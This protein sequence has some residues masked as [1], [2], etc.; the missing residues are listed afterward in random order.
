M[1]SLQAEKQAVR[2]A[3][4]VRRA[5]A[6]RAAPDAGDAANAVFRRD[7]RIRASSIVAGYLPIGDEIDPRPLLRRLHAA[8]HAIAL[9]RIVRSHAPLSFRVWEEGDALEDGPFGTLQPGEAAPAI[10]PE[11][12]VLPLLAFDRRGFRLGYGGGYYD[13]TLAEL[14]SRRAVTAIGIA[15]AAQEVPSVPHDRHDRPLDWVVTE[16]EAIETEKE[17]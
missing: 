1:A 9:P 5:D 8:G 14:R 11:V 15:Y 10:V 16:R 3:V 6:A 13:R 17:D 4:R 7:V 2:A 12:V